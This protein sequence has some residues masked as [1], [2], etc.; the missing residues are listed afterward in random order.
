MAYICPNCKKNFGTQ[1]EEFEKHINHCSVMVED[2][3]AAEATK[4]KAAAKKAKSGLKK[5]W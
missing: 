3:A 5:T 1:K 4:K 2:D